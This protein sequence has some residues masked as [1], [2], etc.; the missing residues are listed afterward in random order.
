NGHLTS[1]VKTSFVI[2]AVANRRSP[3]PDHGGIRRVP[4][5][6][7]S[8][9]LRRAVLRA[10]MLLSLVAAFIGLGLSATENAVANG[11]TRTLS[12]YHLHTGEHLTVTFK[13]NGRY[14]PAALAK[15]DWFMRDWRKGRA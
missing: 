6:S 10:A 12:F 13:V 5:A 3:Q 4:T 11:D 15:L 7:A 9:R 2:L 1:F 14:D 8:Y